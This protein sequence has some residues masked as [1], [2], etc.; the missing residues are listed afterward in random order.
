MQLEKPQCK[1]YLISDYQQYQGPDS[2][3]NFFH[4]WYN[5]ISK[6]EIIL[7]YSK[8]FGPLDHEVAM[9]INMLLRDLTLKEFSWF[10]WRTKNKN[11]LRDL[12]LQEFSGL[13]QSLKILKNK[14][15]VAP[16]KDNRTI[17][18][19]LTKKFIQ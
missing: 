7:I 12:T 16:L 8:K 18:S 13:D 10:D 1:C 19:Q 3:H 5:S 11:N 4:R 6:E 9:T 15:C 17:C 14:G 2:M